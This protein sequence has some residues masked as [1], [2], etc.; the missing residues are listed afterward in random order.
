[1]VYDYAGKAD[2]S[3]G[4]G[5]PKRKLEVTT[6]FLDIMKQQ[7]FQKNSKI[8]YGVFFQIEALLSLKNALLPPIFFLDSKSTC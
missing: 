4:Y 5:N 8:L 3:K 2:L 7:L 6:H 1:M